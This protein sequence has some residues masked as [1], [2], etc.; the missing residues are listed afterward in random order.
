MRLIRPLAGLLIAASAIAWAPSAGPP[1]PESP[2]GES[3]VAGVPAPEVEAPR[4]PKPATL[5]ASETLVAAPDA[6]L[7]TLLLVAL[8]GLALSIWQYRQGPSSKF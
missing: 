7:T 4:A 3:A 2:E 1:E 8:S 5:P 6:V